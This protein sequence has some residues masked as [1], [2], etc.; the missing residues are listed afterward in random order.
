MKYI[1]LHYVLTIRIKELFKRL[2]AAN[3]AAAAVLLSH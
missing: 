1:R 2:C 3:A